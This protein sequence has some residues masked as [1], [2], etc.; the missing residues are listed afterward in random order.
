YGGGKVIHPGDELESKEEK[1]AREARTKKIIEAYKDKMGENVDPKVKAKCEKVLKEGNDLM[2]VGRLQDAVVY[3]ERIMNEMVFKCVNGIL[4]SFTNIAS[5]DPAGFEIGARVEIMG[6]RQE[7]PPRDE[8]VDLER[9]LF[10]VMVATQQQLIQSM[11]HMG[12]TLDRLS[13]DRPRDR[14]DRRDKSISVASSHRGHSRS[15]S[16]IGSVRGSPRRERRHTHTDEKKATRTI[17]GPMKPSFLPRNEPLEVEVPP[18]EV[19]FQ[20]NVMAANDKWRSLP[21]HVRDA[22]PLSRKKLCFHCKDHWEPGHCYLGKCKVHLIEV[23]SN[24]DNEHSPDTDAEGNDSG[25]DAQEEQPQIELGDA[26]CFISSKSYLDS[27]QP[28]HIDIQSILDKHDPVF[29][30]IPLGRPPDRGFE[31]V[32]ELKEGAKPVITM[33]YRHPKKFKDEIEKPIREL[34]DMGHIRPSSSPF[35]SS[36]VL[37]KKDGTMRICIDYR[38][39]NKKTIKN[40][41]FVRDYSQFVAPLTNLTRKGAFRWTDEAHVIFDRFKV[42]ISTYPV[43]TLPDFSWPF[44]LECDDSGSGIGAVLMQDHHLIAYVSRKLRDNKRLY[45]TYYKEMLAIM[46]ALAKFRQYLVGG[47]FVVRTDHNNLKYILEQKEL[48]ERQQ[49]WVTRIQAY[50][51]NIEYVKGKKN[52]V[53]DAL[54]RKPH[55]VAVGSLSEISTDRKFQLL[56]EYSKNTSACDIMD[57]KIQDEQYKVISDLILYKGRIYLVLESKLKKK[58][59]HAFHDAPLA[60]HLGYFKTYR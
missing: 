6:D 31:H 18:E 28:F 24:E 26:Q 51:Y 14:H 34:L 41:R 7:S 57:G 52:V 11:E 53:A 25:H 40:R 45:S 30:D 12:S 33:P 22:F 44:I 21:Q 48:N 56:V 10:R 39:L 47:K 60:R 35:A 17:Y 38:A 15:P 8:Q 19:P 9:E 13:L 36:V 1:E 32:I 49:K 42:T 2:E 54:S 3:Y 5:K 37:V 46:H 43:L 20:D 29:G 16:E 50:D 59:L 23:V 58:I 4:L 55:L 27:G